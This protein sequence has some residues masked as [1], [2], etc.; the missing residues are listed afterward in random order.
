[1]PRN[2]LEKSKSNNLR[3]TDG[4]KI[5]GGLSII[6]IGKRVWLDEQKMGG[7]TA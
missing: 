3:R 4:G 2:S 1:M 7:R 5:K 6:C